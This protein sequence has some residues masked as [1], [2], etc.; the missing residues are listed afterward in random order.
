MDKRREKFQLL[1][2][3]SLMNSKSISLC[4]DEMDRLLSYLLKWLLKATDIELC[5]SVVST[6]RHL[7]DCYSSSND[8]N[9]YLNNAAG[10]IMDSINDNNDNNNSDITNVLFHGVVFQSLHSSLL[11]SSWTLFQPTLD[12]AMKDKTNY[13]TPQLLLQCCRGDL[14]FSPSLS[15]LSLSSSLPLSL[16]LFLLP[17]LGSCDLPSLQHLVGEGLDGYPLVDVLLLWL[18]EGGHREEDVNEEVWLMGMVTS[19]LSIVILESLEES[20]LSSLILP[21]VRS[22]LKLLVQSRK[23]S[24]LPTIQSLLKRCSDQFISL[25][26]LSHLLEHYKPEL[27]EEIV[28]EDSKREGRGREV[29]SYKDDAI[30][31]LILEESDATLWTVLAPIKNRLDIPLIS[32]KDPCQVCS[33]LYITSPNTVQYN[34]SINTVL[35]SIVQYQ[36]QLN[37]FGGGK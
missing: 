37:L 2:L 10:I 15:P 18:P 32:S 21:V 5:V 11:S 36:D 3:F 31:Q 28:S 20:L 13:I 25:L 29:K 26:S 7:V 1:K 23:C 27:D 4:L 17:S 12:K 24:A 34:E 9:K 22:S 35:S 19:L 30:I 6:Y 14:Y 8:I 16:S 33:L